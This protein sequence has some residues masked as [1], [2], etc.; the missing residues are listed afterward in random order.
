[1]RVFQNFLTKWP[2]VFPVPDQKTERLVKILDDEVVQL[3]SVPILS[4]KGTNFL[5]HIIKDVSCLLGIEKLNT[6]VII[7]NVTASQSDLIGH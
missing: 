1:M 3:F 6:T 2:L 4:D 5:S 7:L